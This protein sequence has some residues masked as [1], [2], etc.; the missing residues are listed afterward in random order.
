METT[1]TDAPLCMGCDQPIQGEP[2]VHASMLNV[3]FVAH[4]FTCCMNAYE[5]EV[6][7][8]LKEKPARVESWLEDTEYRCTQTDDLFRGIK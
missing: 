6:K 7:R 3:V 5:K 1:V 4:D 8:I 2:F